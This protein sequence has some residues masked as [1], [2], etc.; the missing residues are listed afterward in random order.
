MTSHWLHVGFT[1]AG[2]ICEIVGF[3]WLVTSASRERG[4]KF[5][6][7]G[8]FRR[9]WNWFAY[10]LGPPPESAT[11][12]VD[13]SS[14]ARAIESVGVGV[15]VNETEQEFVRRELREV[16]EL[17]DRVHTH[18]NQRIDS[19]T[20]TLAQTDARLTES[21]GQVEAR[22]TAERRTTLRRD[23]RA[24]QLFILGALLSLAGAL[25]G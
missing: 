19:V 15:A 5:A 25:I 10:W 16:R 4:Q 22:H 2:T 6:E 18:A 23:F 14:R 12:E 8:P 1:V 20:E 21:I 7:W 17:I 3:S 11:L 13:V 9:I 24:G